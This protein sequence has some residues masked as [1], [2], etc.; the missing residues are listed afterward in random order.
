MEVVG[1]C[2]HIQS[3]LVEMHHY[4]KVSFAFFYKESE[5]DPPGL[6]KLHCAQHN[7]TQIVQVPEFRIR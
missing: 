5:E 1:G 6:V 2:E 4:L 7:R 3:L